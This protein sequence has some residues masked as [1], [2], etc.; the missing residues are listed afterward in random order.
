MT[1]IEK[2]EKALKK[3]QSKENL[4]CHVLSIESTLNRLKSGGKPT[5]LD[6]A[7]VNYFLY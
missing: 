2:Y 5:V 7:W 3:A 4:K 6:E 1:L